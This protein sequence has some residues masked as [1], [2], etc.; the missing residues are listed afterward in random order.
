MRAKCWSRRLQP[1]PKLPAR[2]LLLKS[3]PRCRRFEVGLCSS[4]FRL[5]ALP[6]VT[7]TV[8]DGEFDG[9]EPTPKLERIAMQEVEDGLI[10][11]DYPGSDVVEEAAAA[12]KTS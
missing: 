9:V 10:V 12:E 5:G 3:A 7:L 2:S 4:T 1:T 11:Y 8:H 6:R